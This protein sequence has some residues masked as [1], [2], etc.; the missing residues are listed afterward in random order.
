METLADRHQRS[1]PPEEEEG[2]GKEQ[3]REEEGGEEQDREE[4]E[5]EEQECTSRAQGRA[6]QSADDY[7]P[8]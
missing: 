5:G 4:G 6:S 8:V 3:V 1:E 7:S 2:E